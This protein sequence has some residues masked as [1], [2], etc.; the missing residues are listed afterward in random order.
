M[1]VSA[2]RNE[3]FSLNHFW[4]T[5]LSRIGTSTL[6]SVL[7]ILPELKREKI[8]KTKNIRLGEGQSMRTG[9]FELRF[10]KLSLSP[11]RHRCQY[12]AEEISIGWR[13]TGRLHEFAPLGSSIESNQRDVVELSRRLV[14]VSGMYEYLFNRSRLL[15]TI[16]DGRL[17]VVLAQD[18]AVP[19]C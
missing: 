19:Q 5:P 10:T 1:T 15:L 4:Q 18:D 17:H 7:D 2:I 9:D 13:E 14:I 16:C 11:T 8:S 12:A 3:F 6:T